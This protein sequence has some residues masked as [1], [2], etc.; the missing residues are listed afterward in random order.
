MNKYKMKLLL[1]EKSNSRRILGQ[2][3]LSICYLNCFLFFVHIIVNQCLSRYFLTEVVWQT[4]KVHFC[5]YL[6]VNED[7]DIVTGFIVKSGEERA[8]LFFLYRLYF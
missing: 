6:L 5:D 8:M 1:A 3:F 7:L 4:I 2:F